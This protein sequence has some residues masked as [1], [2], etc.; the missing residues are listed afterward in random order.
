M[1]KA[2]VLMKFCERSR[3]VSLGTGR[4]DGGTV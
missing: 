1:L 4:I 3:A 2:R